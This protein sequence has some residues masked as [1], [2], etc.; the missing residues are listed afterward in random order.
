M[1]ITVSDM[2]IGCG[3]WRPVKLSEWCRAPDEEQRSA[4]CLGRQFKAKVP[5]N[6]PPLMLAGA[7][8]AAKPGQRVGVANMLLFYSLALYYAKITAF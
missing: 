5:K 2:I 7:V 4:A 8:P 3:W 1:F 6:V